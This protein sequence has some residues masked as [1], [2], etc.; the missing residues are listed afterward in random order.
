M[1]TEAV[2]LAFYTLDGTVIDCNAA[3]ERMSGCSR[4]ELRA[5]RRSD[6]AALRES[7]GRF[8]VLAEASPALIFQ[9]GEPSCSTWACPAWT[10]S[11][12]RPACAPTRHGKA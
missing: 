11:K 1:D 2:G 9:F 6:L 10:A 7:D 3:L 12:R 4:D 5:P 8:R